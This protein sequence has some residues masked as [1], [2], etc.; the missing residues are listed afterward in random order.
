MLIQ[1]PAMTPSGPA[2]CTQGR[3]LESPCLAKGWF[4]KAPRTFRKS[5]MAGVISK[6]FRYRGGKHSPHLPRMSFFPVIFPFFSLIF[7]HFLQTSSITFLIF[8]PFHI[9][10]LSL[11]VLGVGSAN[12]C[13]FP[14]LHQRHHCAIVA[15]TKFCHCVTLS[16]FKSLY[17]F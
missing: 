10:Y 6:C 16:S 2:T 14:K 12:C 8:S 1:P 3:E 15:F 4:G 11:L 5:M 13:N 17:N 9:I 7:F